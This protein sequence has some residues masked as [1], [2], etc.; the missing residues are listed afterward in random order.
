MLK[1]FFSFKTFVFEM[2]TRKQKT[3][4]E[5]RVTEEIT[6]LW[7]ALFILKKQCVKHFFEARRMFLFNF[8]N[9]KKDLLPY[10]FR[11]KLWCRPPV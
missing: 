4:Q 10:Q 7:H 5:H 3:V 2:K 9:L 6:H 1:D 8:Y 11:M